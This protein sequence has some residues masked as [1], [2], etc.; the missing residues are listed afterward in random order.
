MTEEKVF[1]DEN[2]VK[3]TNARFVTYAKTHA[4]SGI[5]SVSSFTI[6]PS[7]KGP[8]IVAVLG[9]IGLAVKW[10]I[11]IILIGA[12]IAWFMSLKNEYQ[13]VL[14]SASG[15]EDALTD[16]DEDFI[17]RVVDAV[18]ESIIYRG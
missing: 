5:T 6:Y 18:N 8:I 11:G 3:V 14:S 9:L 2:G 16:K 13:V 17:K 10:W 1:F 4:I 15:N 7:K 12:A